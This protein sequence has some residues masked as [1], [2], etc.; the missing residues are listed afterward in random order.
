MIKDLNCK[1]ADRLNKGDKKKFQSLTARMF[2][3]KEL[4]AKI[5]LQKLY[6]LQRLVVIINVKTSR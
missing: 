1:T 5:V 6:V 4:H 3:T 2:Y